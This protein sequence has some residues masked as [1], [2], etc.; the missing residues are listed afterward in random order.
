MA[1]KVFRVSYL[2]VFARYLILAEERCEAVNAD[3][4]PVGAI[5]LSVYP[6]EDFILSGDD[7]DEFRRQLDELFPRPARGQGG[8]PRGTVAAQP[9]DPETGQPISSAGESVER[10]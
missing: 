3:R 6:G 2:T 10:G 5:R 9:F 4:I 7:A 1:V 8:A